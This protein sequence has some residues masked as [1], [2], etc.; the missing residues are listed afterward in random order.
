MNAKAGEPNSTYASR[1]GL[2]G[3][4]ADKLRGIVGKK[5]GRTAVSDLARNRGVTALAGG[6]VPNFEKTSVFRGVGGSRLL[7]EYQERNLTPTAEQIQESIFKK[8]ELDNPRGSQLANLRAQGG[9]TIKEKRNAAFG[10]EFSLENLAIYLSAHQRGLGDRGTGLISTTLKKEEAEKFAKKNSYRANPD[11]HVGEISMPNSRIMNTAKLEKMTKRFG[12]KRVAQV[13]RNSRSEANAAKGRKN[14]FVGFDVKDITEGHFGKEGARD[15]TYQDYSEEQ[16]IALMAGGFVPNFNLTEREASLQKDEKA[17]LLP[18]PG[19]KPDM[20]NDIPYYKRGG[21]SQMDVANMPY[22]EREAHLK[23]RRGPRRGGFSYSG[24]FVPNFAR[25]KKIAMMD[26]WY[27]TS[28][29]KRG[30]RKRNGVQPMVHSMAIEPNMGMYNPNTT[31]VLVSDSKSRFNETLTHEEF[32]HAMFAKLKKTKGFSERM[33]GPLQAIKGDS[34]YRRALSDRSP[35]YDY[36]RNSPAEGVLDEAFAQSIGSR[37]DKNY[38]PGKDK[39]MD[40]F[41][42]LTSSLI[43]PRMEQHI[44][45]YLEKNGDRLYD[46]LSKTKLPA[47]KAKVKFSEMAAGFVPNFAPVDVFHGTND[48]LFDQKIKETGLKGLK[49]KVNTSS[50]SGTS[51]NDDEDMRDINGRGL[52]LTQD[53]STAKKYG[54]YVFKTS[55]DDSEF[56]DYDKESKYGM[57]TNAFYSNTK[58]GYI[59]KIKGMRGGSFTDKENAEGS[60]RTIPGFPNLEVTKNMVV[61]RGLKNLNFTRAMAGGFVPNFA[62]DTSIKIG[63]SNFKTKDGDT[64]TADAT[65]KSLKDF[66][67]AGVDAAESNQ[68]YGPEATTYADGIIGGYEEFQNTINASGSA[69]Y[70]RLEFKNADLARGLVLGGYG[71]PD[72]RYTDSYMGD[73]LS[74]QKAEKR[75]WGD[76]TD[77]GEGIKNAEERTAKSY[78]HPKAIQYLTQKGIS[79]ELSGQVATTKGEQ[80][81]LEKIRREKMTVGVTGKEEEKNIQAKNQKWPEDIFLTL[82]LLKTL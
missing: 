21:P 26:R 2:P 48:A 32:G 79:D 61:S 5:G 63:K 46:S 74:A 49:K 66:R 11:G 59:K 28:A 57:G 40:I 55:V 18:H 24:G 7:Q 27:S 67:L 62:N 71:V 9:T 10:D 56:Y 78:N 44:R 3:G 68:D 51:F 42:G 82:T 33:Q 69:A 37:F 75:I 64:V 81:E 34:T 25:E 50:A 58:K 43:T 73:V 23:S 13:L 47:N 4:I 22:Y 39:Q 77:S 12:A 41:R 54:K 60:G 30:S 53:L 29:P 76:L 80:K 45:K 52:F 20:G 1:G 36:H 38:A 6:F 35:L 65:V 31:N 8:K 14:K 19:Y 70:D 16:E 15:R 72:L 17:G